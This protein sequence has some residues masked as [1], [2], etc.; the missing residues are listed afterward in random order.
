[1][2]ISYDSN[3]NAQNISARHLSFEQAAD[4]DLA[5]ALVMQD[6]RKAYPE[7]R[8]VAIGF[9]GKRLHVLCFAPTADGM[10]VISFRKAN[11]REGA[12]YEQR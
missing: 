5:T 2:L 4:F 8:F 1:M 9:L 12:V 7:E 10:R 6:V 3:K 11:E